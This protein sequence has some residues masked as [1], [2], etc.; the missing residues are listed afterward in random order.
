MSTYLNRASGPRRIRVIQISMALVLL[1]TIGC[2][3]S[4]VQAS[5]SREVAAASQSGT[6]ANDQTA[7]TTKKN[8]WSLLRVGR[9][10]V[11]IGAMVPYCGGGNLEPYIQ[12]VK[13]HRVDMRFVLTMFV[14]YPRVTGACLGEQISLERR[15]PVNG[16]VRDVKFY[17]GALSPPAR[18]RLR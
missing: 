5:S 12:R 15:I 14:R 18:R 10:G 7:G 16:N 13:G 9:R 4:G 1:A 6:A 3:G 2:G 17:D 11:D 8:Q